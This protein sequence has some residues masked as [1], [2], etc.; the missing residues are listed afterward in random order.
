[1]SRKQKATPEEKVSLVQRY[2]NGEINQT[3]ASKIAGIDISS[4]QLWIKRYEAEGS[5]AFIPAENNR[6]YDVE[7]KRQAVENYLSCGGGLLE[8]CKRYSIRSTW[9]L[10]SWI[11][12][13]NSGK[14]FDRK[15]SGGS[16]MTKTRKATQEER[17]QIAKECLEAECNYGEIAI[18]YDV[19]YQQVYTWVKKFTELGEAGL[20]DRRG[21]RT[22][23]QEPRTEI[24]EL[25]I[26]VAKLEHENYMLQM[27]RDLLKKVEDLERRDAFRK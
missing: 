14:D 15:M 7:L 20:E 5:T 6:V 2:L 19:S 4:F 24:E 12:V 8:I 9:Q 3:Q 18:K 22:A 10:R 17:V 26:Q 1:M 16:R 13:Y 21:K 23:D 27:E 11:K 25:K